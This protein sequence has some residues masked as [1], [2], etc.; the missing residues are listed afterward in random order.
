MLDVF[1]GEF[2][3]GGRGF[4]GVRAEADDEH[5][6]GATGEVEGVDPGADDVAVGAAVGVE[7]GLEHFGGGLGVDVEGADLGGAHEAEAGVF[8]KESAEAALMKGAGRPMNR[9]G[10]GSGEIRGSLRCALCAPVEMTAA[11]GDEAVGEEGAAGVVA[12]SR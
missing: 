12:G 10:S 8:L 2:V 5:A 11:V 1:E 6:A 7:W 4:G 9:Y 3:E